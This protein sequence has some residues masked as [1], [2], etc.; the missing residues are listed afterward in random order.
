MTV[1]AKDIAECAIWALG[2]EL[3]KIIVDVHA[4]HGFVLVLVLVL[5]FCDSGSWT[6]GTLFG[7]RWVSV[8]AEPWSGS[9]FEDEDD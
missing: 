4:G 2:G 5:E 7:F 9:E 1:S 6:N 3:G 8:S